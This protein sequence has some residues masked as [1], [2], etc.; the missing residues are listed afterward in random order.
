MI[1]QITTNEGNNVNERTLF[2]G[3]KIL[4]KALGGG[5]GRVEVEDQAGEFWERNLA[6]VR[7]V[8]VWTDN[9]VLLNHR[10]QGDFL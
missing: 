3:N 8:K 6:D 1:V 4:V 9:G 5:K 7:E 10:T 2:T